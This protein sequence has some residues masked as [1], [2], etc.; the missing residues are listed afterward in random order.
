MVSFGLSADLI[1]CP[2]KKKESIY[3]KSSSDFIA[4][5]K[6]REKSRTSIREEKLI[7]NFQSFPD[8]RRLTR[9]DKMRWDEYSP[10]LKR[11]RK[12]KV[13]YKSTTSCP[14]FL[15]AEM[16]WLNARLQAGVGGIVPINSTIIII[17]FILLVKM[18]WMWANMTW[19]LPSSQ[20]TPHFNLRPSSRR[21]TF[22]QGKGTH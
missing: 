20:I 16:T 19:Y 12:R 4:E 10:F 13:T 8:I 15:R 22:C 17:I 14:C 21:L 3:K 11:K 2:V 9:R 1:W 6:K 7:C 5:D 18:N